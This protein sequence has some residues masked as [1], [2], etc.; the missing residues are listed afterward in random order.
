M[1]TQQPE[2]IGFLL[3][4]RF[5]MVSLFSALEPLRVVNR[6]AGALFS[7]HFL[8]IDGDAVTSSSGIPVAAEAAIASDNEFSIIFVCASFEPEQTIDKRL[9]NWL[10]HMD[11]KGSVLG[12]IE[13]G[14]YALAHANLLEGHRIA[15]HWEA[16]HAF[17]ESF[18][19]LETSEQLYQVDEKRITCAGGVSAMDMTLHLIQR[20]HGKAL[21]E[22]V[23]AAFMHDPM[24]ESNQYQRLQTVQRLAIRHKDVAKVIDLM[25]QHIEEPLSATQLA[26]MSGIELRKLERLFKKH[27]H[28]SPIA[29]YLRLRLERAR[30]LLKQTKMS[31]VEVAVACGF[32]SPEYFSRRYH[33]VFGLAPREDRKLAPELSRMSLDKE[34]E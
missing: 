26:V 29:F 33:T 27:C 21:R 3:Q 12:G 9:I 4:P 23:C 30:Q 13:T 14:C 6:F 24:R 20:Q 18:A 32:R 2:R 22:Q 25:E 19:H 17:E 15:L 8:S 1:T 11:R 34:N 7:W 28:E 16:K 31:V 5:S 10:R